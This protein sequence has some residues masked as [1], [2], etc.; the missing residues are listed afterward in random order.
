MIRGPIVGRCQCESVRFELKARPLFTHACHCLVCRRRSGTAFGLS[1]FILRTDL[2]VLSGELRTKQISSRTTV[3][4]CAT[5]D[6][7]IYSESTRF[8]TT[9][10]V[11]GGTFDD[12]DVV[13][14]DAHIWVKRKHPWIALPDDVPLFDEDYDI[15]TAW[16]QESLERMNTAIGASS[17]KH[18]P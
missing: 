12:P 15:N 18:G 10:V 3:H 9:Y 2:V 16:P 6:T 17:S 14:P 5:C 11:R 13:K 1:T 4:L 8:P 7:T